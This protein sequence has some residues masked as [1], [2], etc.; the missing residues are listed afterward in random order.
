MC[1]RKQRPDPERC[2]SRKDAE[3][4][5]DRQ[6]MPVADVEVAGEREQPVDADERQQRRARVE[7]GPRASPPR[8]AFA[9]VFPAHDERR[10]REHADEHRRDRRLYREGVGEV[11]PPAGRRELSV[12]ER[13]ALVRELHREQRSVDVRLGQQVMLPCGREHP[14]DNPRLILYL[15]EK[16]VLARG[17][18]REGGVAKAIRR[19]DER[20]RHQRE[21]EEHA[22]Q[23]DDL[24]RATTVLDSRA[25]ECDRQ[26]PAVDHPGDQHDERDRREDRSRKLRERATGNEHRRAKH[27]RGSHPVHYDPDRARGCSEEQRGGHVGR[28]E[29]TVREE[30]GAEHEETEAQP[31][32]LRRH[33]TPGPRVDKGAKRDADERHHRA[34]AREESVGIV[35]AEVE[36]LVADHI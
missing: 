35:P 9:S 31:P 15:A 36:V 6:Q 7:T 21:D 30:R 33:Q 32:G 18:C 13:R 8:S 23:D 11:P 25:P 4:R 34:G 19:P 12:E 28:D 14:P 1:P 17:R 3:R 2:A 5:V 20:P 16:R 26:R 22:Q 29:R 10:E 24:T 27:A